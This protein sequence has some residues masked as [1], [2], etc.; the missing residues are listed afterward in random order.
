[1]V[2]LMSTRGLV[3]CL[4]VL[5]LIGTALEVELTTEGAWL[6]A[7]ACQMYV[8]GILLL[9]VLFTT[10]VVSLGFLV[11]VML[12]LLTTWKTTMAYFRIH[13]GLENIC[14]R[15]CYLSKW[16][17]FLQTKQLS[18]MIVL[19]VLDVPKGYGL[20]LHYIMARA[21]EACGENLSG[22][23]LHGRFGQQMLHH[24]RER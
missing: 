21:R 5:L 4:K 20:R 16:I 11:L 18:H 23:V 12:L 14:E 1:V 2:L 22:I 3:R 13:G 7:V 8:L 10:R 24:G 19:N 17:S 6:G 15:V 9:I